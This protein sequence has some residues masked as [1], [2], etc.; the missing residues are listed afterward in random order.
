MIIDCSSPDFNF[1]RDRRRVFVD[2]VEI[3]GVNYID[4]DAGFVR[5]L[6][7][8]EG[9]GPI[10]THSLSSELY[11]EGKRQGWYMPLY[12]AVSKTIWGKIE[13]L[14]IQDT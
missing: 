12:G 5:T 6:H 10:A 7:V 13:L 11:E 2:G 4:T 14:P 3:H 9:V 1:E 8:I